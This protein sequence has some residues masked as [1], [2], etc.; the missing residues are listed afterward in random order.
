MKKT[1]FLRDRNSSTQDWLF[2]TELRVEIPPTITTTLQY[3]SDCHTAANS[4]L[5]KTGSFPGQ[6]PQTHQTWEKTSP[7]LSVWLKRKKDSCLPKTEVGLVQYAA[8]T[9]ILECID[10][11]DPM[12]RRWPPCSGQPQSS[13]AEWRS[14]QATSPDGKVPGQTNSASV[15]HIL[16]V[17]FNS[18]SFLKERLWTL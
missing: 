6:D 8:A 15:G 13:M 10:C 11:P 16:S 12:W 1:S 2:S 9:H 7:Y 3:S 4:W 14:S 5:E 18:S 17:S